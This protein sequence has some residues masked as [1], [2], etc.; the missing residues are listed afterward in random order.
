VYHYEYAVNNQ[1]LDRSIQSFSVP[2]GCGVAISN[3]GFHAPLNEHGFANDGTTGSAGY[4]N[5]PWAV[6]QTA[7]AVT[8]SS[9]TLAQN[10]NANALRWGTMYNFRFD[11]TRPPVATNATVGFYKTGEPITV[12]IQSPT[13]D[14]CNPLTFV[15]AVSR[16][17]HGTAGTF[18][19]NLPLSGS[20]GVE[21]RSGGA[22]GDHTIVF[23]F[24][25][26]I[27]SG[28]AAVTAGT[29][30]VAG[31]PTFSSNTMTV[32]VT[33]VPTVQQITVTLTGVTDSFAQTLPDTTLVMKALMGDVNGNS[34]VSGS[35]VGQVKLDVGQTTDSGN[36]HADVGANGSISASDVSAV[37][38]MAG[39]SLP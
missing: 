22:N 17:T 2:L 14:S 1:N 29:G 15:S 23:T 35:D 37:K 33:G 20:P 31:S 21:C 24:T 8:W 3:V 11:S 32:N 9:E 36:F 30:S 13:P 34:A 5:T 25:N 39:A 18:D 27:V 4:S 38:S 12:A 16:K 10:P 28:N 26:D 7:A 19:I 6:D